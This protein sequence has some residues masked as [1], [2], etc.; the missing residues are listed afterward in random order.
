MSI[1]ISEN[2]EYVNPNKE[3]VDENLVAQA[4]ELRSSVLLATMCKV[5]KQ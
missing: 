2:N 1:F 4:I 5:L 3:N